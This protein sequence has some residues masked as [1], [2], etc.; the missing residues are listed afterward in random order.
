MTI[1]MQ[2]VIKRHSLNWGIL[3][4]LNHAGS[5]VVAPWVKTSALSLLGLWLQ[6]WQKSRP[7]PGNI[8]MPWVWPKELYSNKTD[9]RRRWGV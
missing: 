3:L 2:E 7:W 6:L 9:R 1:Y 4:Y 8:C 5:S